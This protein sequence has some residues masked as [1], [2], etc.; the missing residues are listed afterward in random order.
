MVNHRP[1]ERQADRDEH[2]RDFILGA[3]TTEELGTGSGMFNAVQ[4]SADA[5]G[6]ASLGT[7]FFAHVGPG[8]NA[9]F[10]NAGCS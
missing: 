8:G 7:A 10:N 4:Q 9:D 6:V 2:Q 3:A 1:L 5:I